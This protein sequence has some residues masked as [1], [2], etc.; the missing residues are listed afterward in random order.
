MRF[1][2]S[3]NRAIQKNTWKHFQD[4]AF[5]CNLKLAQQR[6]L[7]FYQTRSNA[8]V[9]HDPLPAEFIETA[10]CM[11]TVEQIYQRESERPRVALKANSQRGSPDLPSQEARSSW[12]TQSEVRSFRV[13]GCNIADYRIPGIPLST[14]QERTKT[15][16]SNQVF[17]TRNNFFKI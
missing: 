2:T 9:L 6:G 15:T 12:E 3:K 4:T 16:N 14:V 10:V 17:N 11:K 7:R 13:T 1:I 8:V 5:W